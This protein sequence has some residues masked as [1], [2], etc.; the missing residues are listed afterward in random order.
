MREKEKLLSATR[1]VARIGRVMWPP[2]RHYLR[3]GKMS[4][5]TDILQE[6]MFFCAKQILIY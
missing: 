3:G 1:G 6:K 5:K 2:E 4:G